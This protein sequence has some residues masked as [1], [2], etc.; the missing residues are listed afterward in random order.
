MSRVE[1]WRTVVELCTSSRFSMSRLPCITYRV[2]NRG[3]ISL[4]VF[5]RGD[6]TASHDICPRRDMLL[7][8]NFPRAAPDEVFDLF[9]AGRSRFCGMCTRVFWV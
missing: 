9:L 7:N 2:L 3:G 6:E 8:Y 4:D 5:D 1:L